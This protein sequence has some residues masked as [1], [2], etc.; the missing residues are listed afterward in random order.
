M[1]DR[2][3]WHKIIIGSLGTIAEMNIFVGNTEDLQCELVKD[4]W[5]ARPDYV[6]E[7]IELF[8]NEAET[9]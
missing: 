3:H 2:D 8:E 5:L 7:S 4:S 1:K 6:I 9:V